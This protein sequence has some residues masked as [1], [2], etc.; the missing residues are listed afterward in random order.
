MQQ[1]PKRLLSIDVLRAITMLLMIFVNDSSGVRNVPDWIDHAPGNAD[2]MGFADTIFPAFLFIVG[3]SLPFAIKNRISKGNS[4]ISILIYIITRSAALII[5]G[6][7]HV[8]LETYSTAAIL[9]KALWAI[10]I[11]IGFFLIWLDYPETMNK[12]KRYTLS[13]LGIVLLIAMAIIYKGSEDGQIT[14]MRPQWWGI[15]GIIGWAYLICAIIYLLSKGKLSVLVTA[16]ILFI[17]INIGKHTGI[18]NGRLFI[19]GD[20]SSITLTMGG[21]IIT[22]IY[23]RLVS[24][25]KTQRLWIIFGLTGV[26]LIVL[27]LL[28]RPYADGISKIRSTPA[29]IFICSGITVLVFELMIFLVDVK[30]KKNWFKIIWPAGTSTLTCYLMPYFQVFLMMYFHIYFP[31]G[32]NSGFG[33]L[34]RSMAVAFVLIALV[35]L[36]EK[37]RIRLKV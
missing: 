27:G 25:G 37:K 31:R 29:W 19:I 20:A 11:T 18:I 14:W 5:M 13:G 2:A 24:L 16:L 36:M 10:L 1:L 33:G 8:N 21:I 35:G 22:E 26:L 4:F 7:F 28:I 17:A 34:A 30:G 6:F 32:F 3:L 15:L 9:P 23:A 12:A